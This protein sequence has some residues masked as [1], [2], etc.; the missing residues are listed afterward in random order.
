MNNFL[1]VLTG[2][3][4]SGKDTIIAKLLEKFPDFK[5]VIT[6]TSRILRTGEING[7]DYNFV[8][9]EDFKDKITQGD[10]EEY[11]EY[12]GNLYGTE[13]S[14]LNTEGD[15]IW[16][17][18]PSRAGQIKDL[19][20]NKKLLVIYLTVDD[21]TVYKRLKLRGLSQ[22]EIDNRM[23]DDKVFWEKYKENYDFVVE[24]IPGQL[25]LT[26]DKIVEIIEDHRY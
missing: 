26:L 7:I 10:F 20:K 2:K 17:I 1:I 8:S 12:G 9:K 23:R 4:A 21:A 11:V 22:Q 24:N 25:D 6:T 16:R 14:Q 19:I 3:T 5:K 18:D 15:L 13:K